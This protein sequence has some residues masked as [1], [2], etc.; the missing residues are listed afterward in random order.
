MASWKA[1][2]PIKKH[3]LRALNRS[4]NVICFDEPMENPIITGTPQNNE[5]NQRDNFDQ[6]QQLMDLINNQQKLIHVLNNDNRQ[7]KSEDKGLRIPE[8][9]LP[10]F[11]GN[12]RKN[13]FKFFKTSFDS[14]ISRTR[15]TTIDK[16]ALLRSKLAGNALNAINTLSVTEGNYSRAWEILEKRFD[17]PRATKSSNVEILTK[18]QKTIPNN[19]ESLLTFMQTY[20]GELQNLADLGVNI[21]ECN[22]FI[23]HHIL[24][25]LDKFTSKRFEDTL[26][27][28]NMEPTLEQLDRFMEKEY[29]INSKNDDEDEQ[30][31][32]TYRKEMKK[33]TPANVTRTH[34]AE[35]RKVNYHQPQENCFLC[36][37]NHPVTEC[38][39][40]ITSDDRIA[41]LRH[42]KLCIYCAQH[43]YDYRSPCKL[44]E[45]L[46]CNVKNCNGRHIP[47]LHVEY[48]MKP[49]LTNTHLTNNKSDF[50]STII[51]PTAIANVMDN[52]LTPNPI[53]CL[54]DQCSQSSYITEDLAQ[55][56]SLHKKK[57]NVKIMWVGGAIAGKSQ[58]IVNLKIKIN[59][60]KIIQTK[61]LVV[62]K[63]TSK[64]PTMPTHIDW[65][66]IGWNK[67]THPLAD[68]CF[69][70]PSHIPILLGSNILPKI[71]IE[72]VKEIN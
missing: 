37:E 61:A 8:I 47:E 51:L 2:Q 42:Y 52:N 54:I 55:K 15:A 28:N 49:N 60:Q 13:N 40:F 23:M 5:R 4:P 70:K 26:Q 46:R 63:V 25:K 12:L 21:S 58:W 39:K 69:N 64:L 41:L 29:A 50:H 27:D 19:A 65:N 71:I 10:I 17:N 33:M 24:S 32:Q 22:T 67:D 66:K 68:P 48:N 34:M 9:A 1:S 62:K 38:P 36:Q 43:R 57:T 7:T 20:Q 53:R 35:N 16:F 14:V 59:D 72:G 56:L 3:R 31:E 45:T 11:E 30:Y 6:I 44:R 18:L